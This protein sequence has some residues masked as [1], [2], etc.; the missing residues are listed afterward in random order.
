MRREP[1]HTTLSL[2]LL[3]G[4]GAGAAQASVTQGVGLPATVHAEKDPEAAAPRLTQTASS[5][6]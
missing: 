4:V 6:N 1:R 2:R 5:D 3:L